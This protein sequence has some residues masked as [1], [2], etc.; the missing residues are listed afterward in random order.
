M[1]N[2]SYSAV[3]QK[4][5]YL[6]SLFTACD[7]GFVKFNWPDV[8]DCRILSLTFPPNKSHCCTNLV[9]I[10]TIEILML[11]F[12]LGS[13][14][15]FNHRPLV[16]FTSQWFTSLYGKW[17]L[18][19]MYFICSKTTNC[20]WEPMFYLGLKCCSILVCKTRYDRGAALVKGCWWH[21]LYAKDKMEQGKDCEILILRY[22]VE[23]LSIDRQNDPPTIFRVVNPTMC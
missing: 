22:S 12:L 16:S 4:E 8:D 18:L 20:L 3:E 10:C 15:C 17:N 5:Q 14:S 2:L 11:L 23:R 9:F 13:V 7:S 6:R 21:T 1:V 19:H